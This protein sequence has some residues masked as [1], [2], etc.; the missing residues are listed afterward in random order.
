M[1]GKVRTRAIALLALGA[2]VGMML[3]GTPASAHVTTSIN[4]I[5]KHIKGKADKRYVKKSTIKTIQGNYAVG[6]S[7]SNDAWSDI[8]FGFQLASAP[9]EHY[10]VEGGTP[11]PECPGTAVTP[12]ATPGHLCV[13]ED[14]G[15]N[16]L[17]LVIFTGTTGA[18]NQASRWG[19]GLWL[20]PAAAG[21]YFSYGTWA[22]TAPAGTS[23]ARPTANDR[24]K[25]GE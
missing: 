20:R 25:A 4:H 11:P 23:P 24:P 12:K 3:V 7:S 15:S 1:K 10:I 17:N 9:E 5:W 16:V 14:T 21:D 22:V 6:G 2:I 13:Y 19:A 18:T 8:S